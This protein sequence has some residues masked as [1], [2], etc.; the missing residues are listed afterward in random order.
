MRTM[1]FLF[2][3][4]V[5][6]FQSGQ[7]AGDLVQHG[8]VELIVDKFASPI[9]AYQPGLLQHRKV[10]GDRGPGH[11]KAGADVPR[12]PGSIFQ[13]GQDLPPGRVGEGFEGCLK[14]QVVVTPFISFAFG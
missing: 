9:V 6:S 5:L 7:P 10:V 13:K 2:F 12:G 3:M 4:V 14:A 1:A 11:I 8:Q